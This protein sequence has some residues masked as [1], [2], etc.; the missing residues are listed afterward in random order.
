MRVPLHQAL[1]CWVDL[2][3]CMSE[4]GG[5]RTQGGGGTEDAS[6]GTH[7]LRPVVE[8]AEFTA[9]EDTVAAADVE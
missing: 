6:G 8:T 7:E 1:G 3:V 2:H 4:G 5:T 9:P